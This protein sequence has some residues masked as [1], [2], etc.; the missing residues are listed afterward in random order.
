M[1][2]PQLKCVFP[3]LSCMAEEGMSF[4]TQDPAKPELYIYIRMKILS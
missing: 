1:H 3:C 2:S 4:L